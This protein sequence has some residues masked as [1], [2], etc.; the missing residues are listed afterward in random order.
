M[1]DWSIEF[2]YFFVENNFQFFEF[3]FD[4]FIFIE[5]YFLEGYVEGVDIFKVFGILE[6][7]LFRWL[8]FLLLDKFLD[9]KDIGF[10]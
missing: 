6:L 2:F 8:I 10:C 1:L 5:F 4:L 3:N 9:F 7:I